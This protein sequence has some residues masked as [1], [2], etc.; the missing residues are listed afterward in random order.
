MTKIA[1]T[2]LAV[3]STLVLGGTGRANAAVITET[4][5][6]TAS[7]FT[8]SGS[9]A[10]PWTGSFT[11]TFDPTIASSGALNVFSSNLPAG[12]G[13]F[14]FSYMGPGGL[15]ELGDNCGAANCSATA[16][17]DTAF[18]DIFPV[19]ASAGLTFHE[20]F[21]GS[22]SNTIS[23]FTS[24]TGTLTPTV[25]SIPLPAALAFIATGLGALGLL[26]WRRKRKLANATPA[27][28]LAPRL[29]AGSGANGRVSQSP[30]RRRSRSTR[31]TPGVWRRKWRE[32][33]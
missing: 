17:T 10:N 28:Y 11:I 18:L 15:L 22:T 24:F 26:G 25:P 16:G 19:S 29:R 14:A 31:P 8:P 27:L 7:D 13:T 9:P 4:E 2:I 32:A 21:V 23:L 1:L 33:F 3:V 5:S 30:R 20:A 12:Y 6:F